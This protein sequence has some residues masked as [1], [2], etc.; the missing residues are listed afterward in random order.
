MLWRSA[1]FNLAVYLNFLLQ[2]VL[3]SPVLLLPER[4]VWPIARF[5]VRSTLLLH[6]IIVGVDDEI[7]GP[8]NIPTGGLIVASK[9]QSAWETLRL[10]ELFARPTF[11]LKRELLWVPLFG[12]YL[13]K[14]GMIP[15]ARGAR[16]AAL[17]QLTRDAKLAVAEG[18]QIIIFPEGTRRPPLAPA[19]YRYGVTRLYRELNVPCLP[20]ALNSGLFWPRRAF[21][22]R[23]GT[24]LLSCLPPI[25]PGLDADRFVDALK[26]AIETETARL[27]E[28]ALQ[29]D[30]TL[31]TAP[32]KR[33]TTGDRNT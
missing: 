5:W 3:F 28:E 25:P 12:W 7:R 26:D 14:T 4:R 6:R 33:D 2:A 10:V 18:R 27:I 31:R 1:L 13:K 32:R 29:V 19:E 20:V 23:Q 17:E 24:I 15:V 8:A 22:H 11:I 21:A 30:P 16:S 9:H